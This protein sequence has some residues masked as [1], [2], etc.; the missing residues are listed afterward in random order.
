M[1]KFRVQSDT[2]YVKSRRV[3]GLSRHVLEFERLGGLLGLIVVP[4]KP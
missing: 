2:K 1:S 3:C 4:C